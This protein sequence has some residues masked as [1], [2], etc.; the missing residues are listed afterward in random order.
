[1][2]GA[3]QPGCARHMEFGMH[4]MVWAER[5]GHWPTYREV[6]V[7]F[8]VSKASAYRYIESYQNVLSI[9]QARK[10]E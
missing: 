8:D 6:M 5:L 3:L 9:D 1:M 10:A 4:F 7:A 2:K